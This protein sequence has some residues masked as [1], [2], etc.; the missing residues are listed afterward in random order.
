MNETNQPLLMSNKRCEACGL[1]C[2]IHVR[3]PQSSKSITSTIP[4]T[5]T[6]EANQ[7][8]LIPPPPNVPNFGDALKKGIAAADIKY[9]TV[10]DIETTNPAAIVIDEWVNCNICK[11]R[12]FSKYLDNHI[13]IHTIFYKPKTRIS[14]TIPITTHTSQSLA[15]HE[16]FT[17]T[18]PTV[19]KQ[20]PNLT[21]VEHFQYRKITD[22]CISSSTNKTNRYSDMTIVFWG[23]EFTTASNTSYAGG[24][25]SY[26]SQD[27][28]RFQIHIVYDS[29]EDYYTIQSKLLKRS[30]YSTFDN[31][32]AS[33]PDRICEQH[34]LAREIKRALLFFKISPR[35]AYKLVRKILKNDITSEIKDGKAFLSQTNNCV[36]LAERLSKPA[37]SNSSWSNHNHGSG[38]FGSE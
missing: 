18:T 16:D 14:S 21:P 29:R 11:A 36:A 33:V 34:E 1:F 25:S 15:R 4:M 10:D 9:S 24:G 2:C 28:E 17:Y 37:N 38:Y 27:W 19:P 6:P 35:N 20:R 7:R 22:V 13:K 31:E 30:S 23:K 5:A 32:D 3:N 26:L 8:V 12:V